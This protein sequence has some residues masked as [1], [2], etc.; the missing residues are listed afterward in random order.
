M[1]P[2]RAA[3]DDFVVVPNV[4]IVSAGVCLVCDL[5]DGQRIVVPTH[6]VASWSKVRKPGEAGPITIK[7]EVAEY[8]GLTARRAN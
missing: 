2:R 3:P 6:S 7:R 1:S 4:L 8:A 5:I